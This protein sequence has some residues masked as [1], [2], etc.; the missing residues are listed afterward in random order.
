[1]KQIDGISVSE[2]K[3]MAGK[4]YGNLVKAD[5]D[6]EKNIVVVDMEMHADGEAYLL[7]NGSKQKDLWGVNLH[8]DKFGANDF[9]EFESMINLRPSQGNLSRG[10]DDPEI[11]KKILGI[12]G[13][14][15]HE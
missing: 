12:I 10:V 7:E 6:I 1:M 15:V 13:Q 5:V 9:V 8:P 3:D 4:M 11:R 14:V 2:L